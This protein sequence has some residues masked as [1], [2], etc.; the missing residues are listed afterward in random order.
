MSKHT[1]DNEHKNIEQV[2]DFKSF[3]SS[4]SNTLKKEDDILGK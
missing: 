3:R 4:L 2:I 1:I